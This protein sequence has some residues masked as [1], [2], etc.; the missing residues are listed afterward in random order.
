MDFKEKRVYR[1]VIKEE[2]HDII[3][4]QYQTIKLIDF[5]G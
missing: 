2:K 5:Q 4:L 3:M 1:R